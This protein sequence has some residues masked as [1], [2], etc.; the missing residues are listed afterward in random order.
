[1]KVKMAGVALLALCAVLLVYG[2]VVTPVLAAAYTFTA[3][4]AIVLGDMA[5]GSA[6]PASSTGSLDGNSPTGYT[7]T[8][9][10]VK[11]TNSL[12]DGTEIATA[13]GS[14]EVWEIYVPV[15]EEEE[16]EEEEVAP[17][18]PINWLLIGGVILIGVLLFL[19]S[20]LIRR[21]RESY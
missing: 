15:V 11:G 8:G 5:P 7:V 17:A 19:L 20:W 6:Y 14:F 3:P 21:R 13:G 10:D 4:T 1:M 16:E 2:V 9:I 12:E 18:E